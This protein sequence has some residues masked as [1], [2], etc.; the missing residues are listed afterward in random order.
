MFASTRPCKQQTFVYAAFVA[1]ASFPPRLTTIA[2]FSTLSF[3]SSTMAGPNSL[4]HPRLAVGSASVN[5]IISSAKLTYLMYGLP[6][7]YLR[8]KKR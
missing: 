2:P 7:S 3:R 6:L 4:S 5:G 1:S 8:R